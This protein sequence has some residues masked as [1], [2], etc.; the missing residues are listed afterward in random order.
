MH[1]ATPNPHAAAM[2]VLHRSAGGEDD[3]EP[4]PTQQEMYN[5]PSLLPPETWEKHQLATQSLAD[6][7][8]KA[9]S[10]HLSLT[11]ADRI[12]NSKQMGDRVAAFL[13]HTKEGAI[14]P[15]LTQNAKLIKANAGYEAGP[16]YA[17][18]API[19][20]PEGVGVETTGLALRPA[21]RKGKFKVCPNSAIC[22][23]P[24]LGETS[25]NYGAA[26]EPNWPKINGQNRTNAF[27]SDP[28]AFAVR[29]H[30]EINRAKSQA[31][32]NGNKLAVRLNVLSDIH[33]KIHEAIIKAH[34]DVDFYDY[35]K[36]DYD[37]I[38][39]NHHY[40]YS[41][42]G[43]TQPEGMN[44]IEQGS[45]KGVSNP[46][47]N[48]GR[49]RS[50]LDQGSNVAMVFNHRANIPLPKWVH[51]QETGKRYRV[52]DGTT[53]DYRPL[54]AQPK[55]SDG[56]IIGLSNLNGSGSSKDAHI[57]SGGFMVK[58]DPQ[59]RRNVGKNG[60]PIAGFQRGPSL[61]FDKKGKPVKG[62]YVADNDTVHVAPQGKARPGQFVDRMY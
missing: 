51:D 35:T 39:P 46:H 54:D 45:G 6:A 61:G 18:Q 9:I 25:G 60:Q 47:Q 7:F 28:E 44:G 15:L 59:L 52:V 13:G 37:P 33:P 58:Y 11:G 5:K 8:N 24:C 27:L 42:T 38:A 12:R 2:N 17:A 20:L 22:E 41:S 53:H 56:V 31:E 21:A 55:G 48:W 32:M 19:M 57:D 30:D 1:G 26:Y 62:E 4:M 34:P 49:M 40:T 16:G 43:L 29:L 50:R 10:H 36:M 14:K 3:A 23:K